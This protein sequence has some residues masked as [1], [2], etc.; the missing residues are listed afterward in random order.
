M[1]ARV[2]FA[3]PWHPPDSRDEYNPHVTTARAERSISRPPDGAGEPRC[4]T[5]AEYHRMAE[6][7]VLARDER[8]E[9]LRGTITMMSPVGSRHSGV[10][11]VLIDGLVARL[12]G[13]A[14]C[15]VQG[16]LAIDEVSEPQPDLMVLKRREDFYRDRHPTPEDVLLLIEVAESLVEFDRGAKCRLYARAGVAEYWI[17]DLTRG[18]LVVHR[19]PQGDAYATVAE[20]ERGS[21]VAPLAFPDCELRVAHIVG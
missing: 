21:A 13:R 9:L 6:A 17:V 20:H 8:I 14:V 11:N 19:S 16:P 1:G 15:S 12:S 4:F 10:L 7:G 3:D 5:R 18:V 2:S